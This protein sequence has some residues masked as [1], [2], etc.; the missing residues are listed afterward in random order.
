M[1]D[2]LRPRDAVP[3]FASFESKINDLFTQLKLPFNSAAGHKGKAAESGGFS[4]FK[5]SVPACY[6]S[7]LFE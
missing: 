7:T 5:D 2:K 3:Q 1:C 6:A 4:G